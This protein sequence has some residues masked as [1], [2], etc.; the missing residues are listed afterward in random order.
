MDN[1]CRDCKTKF[2]NSEQLAIHAKKYLSFYDYPSN[3]DSFASIVIMGI[4]N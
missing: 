2:E 1:E 4:W 3:F